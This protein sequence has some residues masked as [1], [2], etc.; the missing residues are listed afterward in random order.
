MY[1][2]LEVHAEEKTTITEISA[3]IKRLNLD[4]VSIA[5]NGVSCY[6]STSSIEAL[7]VIVVEMGNLL[8]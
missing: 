6:I 4:K 8:Y 1:F 2:I 5:K 3:I 7:D